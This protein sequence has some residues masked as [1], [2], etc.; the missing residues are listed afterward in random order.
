M[1]G[2]DI[3]CPR[4]YTGKNINILKKT[5]G[6]LISFYFN[7]NI[8]FKII[9]RRSVGF[10]IRLNDG[11]FY[12]LYDENELFVEP[13]P[14][15]EIFE[16]EVK[17]AEVQVYNGYSM[18]SAPIVIE[19]PIDNSYYHRSFFFSENKIEFDKISKRLVTFNLDLI[20]KGIIID[21]EKEKR[22][23]KYKHYDT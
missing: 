16:Y 11:N 12:D 7:P 8:A 6:S 22:E 10:D 1:I 21:T 15:A 18:T 9:Y 2:S 3:V 5:V 17:Y 19:A 4:D 20:E 23:K 14:D 13:N